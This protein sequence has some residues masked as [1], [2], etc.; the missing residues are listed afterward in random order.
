[1]HRNKKRISFV[2]S[3]ILLVAFLGLFSFQSDA[4]KKEKDDKK[5]KKKDTK[6]KDEKPQY[7]EI[8]F[9][10]KGS[11]EYQ[12][13]TFEIW[14]KPTYN[15]ME[16]MFGSE[17]NRNTVYFM[18]VTP[19]K[20]AM[21]RASEKSNS[22]INLKTPNMG[23]GIGHMT[24]GPGGLSFWSKM[25]DRRN[26]PTQG[27]QDTVFHQ[28]KP[29]DFKKDQWHYIAVTWK[30]EGKNY[31]SE[32]CIDGVFR[33]KSVAPEFE[34]IT[35]DFEEMYFIVGS[36]EDCN[37]AV[38]S[39]RVSKKVRTNEEILKSFESGLSSD[40]ATLLFHNGASFEKMKKVS[41]RSEPKKCSPKGEIYGASRMVSG[42]SGKAILL[43][44]LADLK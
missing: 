40:D 2:L 16:A 32:M 37:I 30:K 20:R 39:F 1:M 17:T 22:D 27:S 35:F 38:D 5:E 41:E 31:E 10:R 44:V 8:V 13:G 15:T 9:P 42:K 34:D 11:I 14:F 33:K 12:E 26:D 29:I 18:T 19:Y 4:A 23:F 25:I 7:G 43:N 28:I 3:F 6:P 24:S 36:H 21:N